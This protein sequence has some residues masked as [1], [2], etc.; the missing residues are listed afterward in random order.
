[1]FRFQ[2]RP[3]A[4]VEVI[5]EAKFRPQDYVEWASERDGDDANRWPWVN[6][7]KPRL[8]PPSLIELKIDELR[9][10]GQA[11]RKSHVRLDPEEFI[12]GVRALAQMPM[13]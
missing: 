12:A 1:M 7:T 3:D 4:V 11:P 5:A 2:D 13:E 9:K 8:V 6:R 10:R